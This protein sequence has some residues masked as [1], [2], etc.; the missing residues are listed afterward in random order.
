MGRHVY[1][2]NC[3]Q[4]QNFQPSPSC[5]TTK[6][7][8]G[9]YVNMHSNGRLHIRNLKI[10]FSKAAPFSFHPSVTLTS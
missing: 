2:M 1:K 8:F 7:T 3:I 5:S 6:F 9:K 10:T 4:F